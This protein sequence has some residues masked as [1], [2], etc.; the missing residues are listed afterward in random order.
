MDRRGRPALRE[1]SAEL[2]D[3]LTQQ[4]L[5]K[6]Y[7]RWSLLAGEF[8]C[9]RLF[10]SAPGKSLRQHRQGVSHIDHGVQAGAEKIGCAHDQNPPEINSSYNVY[11]E[12]WCTAFTKTS[13]DSCGFPGFCRAD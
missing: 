8:S 3:M 7:L 6:L 5:G 12:I 4:I 2:H 9:Q 1:A 10:D 11:R 13:E